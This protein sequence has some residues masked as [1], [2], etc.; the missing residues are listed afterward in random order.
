LP[1]GV[2]I[3]EKD[4][5]QRVAAFLAAVPHIEERGRI[6]NPLRHRYWVAG[7]EYDDCV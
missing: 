3:T 5:G 7:V 4:R 2:G 6:V 1:E